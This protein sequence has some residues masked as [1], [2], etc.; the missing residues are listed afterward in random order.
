ML[1]LSHKIITYIKK[2]FF[3]GVNFLCSNP[4]HQVCELFPVKFPIMISVQ[5]SI[6][7]YSL[8]LGQVCASTQLLY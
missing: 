5:P 2:P 7:E 4:V 1:L 8:V 6:A 3:T